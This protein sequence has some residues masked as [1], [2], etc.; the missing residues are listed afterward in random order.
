M[1]LGRGTSGAN[2]VTR[3]TKVLMR[4]ERLVVISHAKRFT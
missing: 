4:D 2:D 1:R 3:Y